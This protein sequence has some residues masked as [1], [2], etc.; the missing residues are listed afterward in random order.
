[1]NRRVLVL[2]Q[3]YEPLNI[4]RLRRAI[5]LVLQGKA[6]IIESDSKVVR[7]VDRSFEAPS[8]IKLVYFV[9]KPRPKLQLSR[10]SILARDNYRCQY[11]GQHSSELTIDHVIPRRFGG[12]STWENLVTACKQCNNKKGDKTL[13]QANMKLIKLPKKIKYLPNFS[14]SR[15]YKG[16]ERKEWEKYLV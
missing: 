15:H 5:V 13:Q 14:F 7:T 12:K 6:E 9:R 3:N 2:N 1:M 11:C 10:R 16:I 4:C 8:V